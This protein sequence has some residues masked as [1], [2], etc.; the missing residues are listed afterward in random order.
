MPKEPFFTVF[1]IPAYGC[2]VIIDMIVNHHFHDITRSW[3]KT[4][5]R[6]VKPDSMPTELVDFF[7][8]KA[9]EV[10]EPYSIMDKIIDV[11]KRP[12]MRFDERT[13]VPRKDLIRHMQ[14]HGLGI[15]KGLQ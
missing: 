7:Q 11:S 9:V 4:L 14:K 1:D 12:S 8:R 13:H 3:M 10:P 2:G 15:F 6:N 5:D